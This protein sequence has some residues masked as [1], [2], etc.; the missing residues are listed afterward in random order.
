MTSPASDPDPDARPSWMGAPGYVPHPDNLAPH[1]PM[2]GAPPYPPNEELPPPPVGEA[3][4]RTGFGRPLAASALWAAVLVVLVI[5]VSGPPP[6]VGGVVRL[7]LSCALIGLLTA[8]VTWVVV[9]RHAWP[10]WVVVLVAAPIFW[11]LRTFIQFP[12]G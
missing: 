12:G 4:D 10:F 11:L 1:A 5:A 8:T 2:P 3:R 7:A 9:R 6:G